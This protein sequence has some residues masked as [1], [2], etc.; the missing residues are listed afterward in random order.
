[1]VWEVLTL[2]NRMR[3]YTLTHRPSTQAHG[4]VAIMSPVWPTSLLLQHLALFKWEQRSSFLSSAPPSQGRLPSP[5]LFLRDAVHDGR[6][7]GPHTLTHAVLH[8]FPSSY[9]TRL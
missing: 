7:F 6:R 5:A 8:L 1:M 3:A 2:V 9:S 4:E